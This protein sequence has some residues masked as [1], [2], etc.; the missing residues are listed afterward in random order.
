MYKKSVAVE[1]VSDVAIPTDGSHWFPAP[2]PGWCGPLIKRKL[3]P[4]MIVEKPN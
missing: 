3:P 2:K 4:Y 1:G